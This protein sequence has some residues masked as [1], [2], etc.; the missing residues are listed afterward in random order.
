[1]SQYYITYRNCGKPEQTPLMPDTPKH[2]NSKHN[3]KLLKLQ[4]ATA[5]CV[6]HINEDTGSYV[7]ERNNPDGSFTQMGWSKELRD[8]K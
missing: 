1:M 3:I 4:G 8:D 5:I 6:H 7:E 2:D